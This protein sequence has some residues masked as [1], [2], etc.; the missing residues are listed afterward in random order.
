MGGHVDCICGAASRKVPQSFM[1]VCDRSDEIQP[2]HLPPNERVAMHQHR[3]NAEA[4]VKHLRQNGVDFE[5]K[6]K[7]PGFSRPRMDH[8]ATIPT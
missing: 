2:D 5:A 4:K 7:G 3:K 8:Q 6:G 1:G